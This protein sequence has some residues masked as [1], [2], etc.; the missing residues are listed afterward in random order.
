MHAL[1]GKV[2]DAPMSRACSACPAPISRG[3]QSG[4]CRSCVQVRLN[5]DPI[6]AAN[7]RAGM[8]AYWADPENRAKGKARAVAMGQNLSDAERE[9]RR[10]YGRATLREK[11]V[12]A[13]A[14]LTSEQRADNGRK[15][16]D[17]VLAWC[18]PE[19]RDKYRDLKKR[20]RKAAVAKRIVLDLIAGRAA[21]ILYAKQKAKMAWCPPAR[22]AEYDRLRQKHGAAEAR[23]LTE[24]AM[25]PFERQLARVA[26]GAKLITVQPLRRAEPTMTLGGVSSG[27]W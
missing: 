11:L 12:A 9:R 6:V 19:W 2:A 16:S 23:R 8:T 15:R 20:G 25:S 5:A 17:T 27:N 22:R 1:P 24:A 14:A 13:N 10:Q 4:L 26:A 3:N 18:P 21:P 7:R